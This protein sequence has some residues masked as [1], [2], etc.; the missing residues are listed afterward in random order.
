MGQGWCDS[1]AATKKLL[2]V[3]SLAIA[4]LV[5]GLVVGEMKG[6][7]QEEQDLREQRAEE[8]Y[9]NYT[10]DMSNV[11]T[12]TMM[13]VPLPANR[14]DYTEVQLVE[15]HLYV[16]GFDYRPNEIAADLRLETSVV[17]ETLDELEEQNVVNSGWRTYMLIPSKHYIHTAHGDLPDRPYG[18]VSFLAVITIVVGA[19]LLAY[20]IGVRKRHKQGESE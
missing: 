10:Y 9:G 8:V 20:I 7:M 17:K 15:N 12:G 4:L 16:T 6:T 19:I 1:M 14:D 11:G 13:E 3:I 5:G 2:V 18:T